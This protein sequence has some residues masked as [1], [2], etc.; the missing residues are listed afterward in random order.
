MS[1]KLSR[2]FIEKWKKYF[3]V[4]PRLEQILQIMKESIWVSK[5]RD[6]I[7]AH[8]G[9]PFRTHA[10]YVNFRRKVVIKVDKINGVIV[11][12][13]TEKDKRSQ[14]SGGRYGTQS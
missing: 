8:S 5:C 9:A 2:H 4:E 12:V 1:L 6:M 7:Y 10:I 13:L 3:G 11:T 14:K